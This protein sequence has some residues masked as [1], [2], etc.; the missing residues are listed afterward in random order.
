MDI[1]KPLYELFGAI[2][3]FIYNTLSFQNYG[4]AIIIFTVFTKLLL[5]PFSIKALKSTGQNAEMQK[6]V[7]EINRLFKG[8]RERIAEET[9]K[10]YTKYNFSPMSGCLPQ[11]LQ[12][13]IIMVLFQI[14]REPI[15]YILGKG[16]LVGSALNALDIKNATYSQLE[17]INKLAENPSLIDSIRGFTQNDIINFNFLGINLGRTPTIDFSLIKDLPGVYLPLLLIPILAAATTYLQTFIMNKIN[18]NKADQGQPGAAGMMKAMTFMM[19]AMIAVF[20][21]QVPASMGLY[22][23]VGNIFTIG[24][25]LIMNKFMNKGKKGKDSDII[26][27]KGKRV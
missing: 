21:F 8:N 22:W 9:Q 15:T 6:E 4:F 26:E 25:Q 23:I 14:V 19:P 24:Q 5:A 17:M 20:A 18:Q 7:A 13:P 11:L 2:M 1:L 27:V 12:F 16:A 3:K 10:I